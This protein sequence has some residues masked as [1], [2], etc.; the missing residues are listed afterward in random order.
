MQ[1][2]HDLLLDTSVVGRVC[3]VGDAAMI[4][5]P[6]TG[7]GASKAVR[8]ALCLADALAGTGSVQ[9]G[10]GLYRDGR[11]PSGNALVRLGRDLGRELVLDAPDWR[12]LDEGGYATLIT[13]GATSRTYFAGRGRVL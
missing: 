3:L 11:V 7:G 1:T 12:S 10:L 2:M 5:R 8:D 13:S 9:E 6:H 4:A